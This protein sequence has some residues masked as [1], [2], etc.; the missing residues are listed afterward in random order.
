MPGTPPQG[1]VGRGLCTDGALGMSGCDDP[2]HPGLVKTTTTPPRIAPS[3]I[4]LVSRTQDPHAARAAARGEFVRVSSGV[5]ASRVA[6]EALKPWER[7]L[8]RVHAASM[9]YPDAVF[10]LDAAA[11]FRSLPIFGE[12]EEV[13]VIAPAHATARASAGVRVHLTAEPRSIEEIDG[14]LVTDVADTVVDLAR[15]RHNAVGLAVANAALRANPQLTSASLRAVNEGRASSRWRRHARWPLERAI[16]TPESPLESVSLAAVEW[17]GIP[18]PELQRRFCGP[19][20]TDQVDFWWHA[21]RTA[22]EADGDLKYDGEHADAVR[23][24]RDRRRRDG[25]LRALGVTATAHWAWSDVVDAAGLQA[26]L[27]AAGVHPRYPQDTRQL[28]GLRTT[29]TQRRT[30]TR[31]PASAS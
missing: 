9:R 2:R 3:P 19:D 11:A 8:A 29:L 30:W 18:P 4:A 17:L 24:L 26:A 14:I 31:A 7:Y 25:R 1:G 6:W 12:P 28:H 10:C 15:G 22:G 13:H 5:Y 16:P 20:H 21:T 27:V 23:A